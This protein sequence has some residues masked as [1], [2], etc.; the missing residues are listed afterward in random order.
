[1]DSG[2]MEQ[3]LG[4]L[5]SNALR[6]TSPKGEITL[7]ANQITPETMTLFVVDDGQGIPAADLPR[8][9]DRFYKADA[10]R[11]ENGESGLGLA[12]ARSLVTMHGGTITVESVLGSGTTFRIELPIKKDPKGL[13]NP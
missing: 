6:Y 3:V 13:Q 7:A 5:V 9:F 10:S 8:I 11:T 12:I 1:M 4:N 2:R